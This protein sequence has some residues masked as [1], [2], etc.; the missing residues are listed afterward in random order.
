MTKEIINPGIHV[1][2]NETYHASAGISRSGLWTF[3]QLPHKYW[4]EYLSGEYQRPVD[5]EAFIIGD[6]VHTMLLEPHLYEGNYFVMPKVNRTTKVGK[7]AYEENLILAGDRTLINSDQFELARGMVD[8]M[9]QHK[10]VNDVLTGDI[11]VEHSIF[12]QDQE[13]GIL[14]KARPDLWNS[15]LVADLKTTADA[16]YRGFQISAMKYG[17]FLQAGMI[18]EALK[19]VGIPFDKFLFMCVESK[20]PHSVGLYLLDDEALQF[21]IDLFHQLLRQYAECLNKNEWPDYGIKMLMIPRYATL[22][23]ENE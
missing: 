7:A 13:T 11:K 5:K 18:Y 15:P 20:K 21:G 12:W 9:K 6:L 22:E 14:C 17:Y 1:I 10:V 19:A 4:Y 16:G 23:M 3:K 8:S 2:S